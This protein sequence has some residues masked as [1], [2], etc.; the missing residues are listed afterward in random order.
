M[1]HISILF[2]SILAGL[3]LHAEKEILPSANSIV[4]RYIEAQGGQHALDSIETLRLSG[5]LNSPS[6]PLGLTL[7]KKRPNKIRMT[8]KYDPNTY[9]TRA[10]NGKKLWEI[11]TAGVTRYLP[12]GIEKTFIRDA[13]LFS[14]VAHMKDTDSKVML[15]GTENVGTFPCYKLMLTLPNQE[16]IEYCIDKN[17]YLERKCS[18]KEGN[19]LVSHY[20]SEF[21]KIGALKQ[22][23]RIVNTAMNKPGMSFSI[24]DVDLNIGIADH[25][26]EPPQNISPDTIAP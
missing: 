20:F 11:D 22:P 16:R 24:H 2:A 9:Y 18:Y 26:F 19:T 14:H 12:K 25:F 13:Q 8:I 7:I 3:S 6:G 5:T 21:Q 17:E 15:L 1:K 10:Y 4:E 23:M